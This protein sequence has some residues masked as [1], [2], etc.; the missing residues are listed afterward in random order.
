MRFIRVCGRVGDSWS[1]CLIRNDA[2]ALYRVPVIGGKGHQCP[3]A[4]VYHV[5]R[6]H[7]ERGSART[8]ADAFFRFAVLL[9]WGRGDVPKHPTNPTSAVFCG[10]ATLYLTLHEP[11]QVGLAQP[12]I[13]KN[14]TTYF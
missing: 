4:Q 1:T 5:A 13:L 14:K 10:F 6:W 3:V 7:G 8:M 2:N 12:Y 9:L 11:Y